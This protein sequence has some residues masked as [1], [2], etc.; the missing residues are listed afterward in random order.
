[1]VSPFSTGGLHRRGVNNH[2]AQALGQ[3][4][5]GGRRQHLAQYSFDPRTAGAQA[6]RDGLVRNRLIES[7]QDPC[8]F[9]QRL[10]DATIQ[11]DDPQKLLRVWIFR[12]RAKALNSRASGTVSGGRSCKSSSK[13]VS[14][15]V[16]GSCM[17][18]SPLDERE[19]G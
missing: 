9:A 14:G 5:H 4:G 3:R 11:Q 10:I 16:G 19:K 13:S 6:L 15:A 1:M 18:T 7:S 8:H 2:K 17:V 12:A